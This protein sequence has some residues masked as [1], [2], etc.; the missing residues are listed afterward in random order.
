MDSVRK[1]D[2]AI[3]VLP[4]LTLPEPAMEEIL[5]TGIQFLKKK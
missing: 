3:H 2:G 5:L 4:A 1:K